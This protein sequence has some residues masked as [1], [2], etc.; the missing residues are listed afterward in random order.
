[1]LKPLGCASGKKFWGQELAQKLP[2][3]EDFAVRISMALGRR[4]AEL[5]VA[6]R[7]LFYDPFS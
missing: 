5:L 6:K 7:G 2:L 3:V 4:A 1:V